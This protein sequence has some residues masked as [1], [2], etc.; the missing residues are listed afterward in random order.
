MLTLIYRPYNTTDT[1]VSLERT[2]W[3]GDASSLEYYFLQMEVT[4]L[5]VSKRIQ[6]T[7]AKASITCKFRGRHHHGPTHAHTKIDH[8][9]SAADVRSFI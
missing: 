4:F 2:A 5:Q 6:K 7:M 3:R 8:G 9:M 1:Y